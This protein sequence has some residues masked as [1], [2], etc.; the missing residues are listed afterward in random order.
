MKGNYALALQ[1]LHLK[2]SPAP[3]PAAPPRLKGESRSAL[4]VAERFVALFIERDKCVIAFH[5][6]A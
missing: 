4:A 5:A 6:T 1:M 3:T 2:N